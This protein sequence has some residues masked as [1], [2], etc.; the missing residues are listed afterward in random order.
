MEQMARVV[1]RNFLVG[2]AK[3]ALPAA[4]AV[5]AASAMFQEATFAVG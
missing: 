3:D 5:T 2:L 1:L 4:K